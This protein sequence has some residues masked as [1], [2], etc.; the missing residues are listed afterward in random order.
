MNDKMHVL[1]LAPGCDCSDVGESWSCCQWVRGLAEHCEVTLLTLQRPGR[2]PVAGQLP[3]VHVVAWND[4]HW[5]GRLERFSSMLKPGY[6]RFYLQARRWIRNALK[7]GR[8]F[9][10]MHQLGPLAL[11]YPSP[12][13]G[14]GVPLIIGPLAG[15]LE[16]P[17][18]FEAE[19]RSAPWYTR[20]RSLD[21]LRLKFDPWLRNTY[22]SADVVI[23][24]AP[25]VKELLH[26]IPVARFEVAAETGVHDVSPTIRLPEKH[27]PELRLLY[28]GRAIRTKGL[29]DLVQAMSL[30]ADIPHLTLDAV[31]MGEDLTACRE[32]AAELHL[33]HR[34]HFHGWIPRSEVEGL[35]EQSDVF[36]FPSFREPS[37]NAVFE[38]LSHG[39]PVITTDRGGPGYVVDDE[40]GIRVPADNPAQLAQDLATAI[41]R[42]ATNSELREH[43][44]KGAAKRV[45][46]LALWPNKIS[47]MVDLYRDVTHRPQGV[48]S[49][50]MHVDECLVSSG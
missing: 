18:A 38:A 2:T 14:L 40:C 44:S 29:R 17:K 4:I 21:Q 20:L 46:Q 12:A 43:L 35:Y 5:R 1:I 19:C 47:R 13:V 22:A 23:G 32:L 26:G 6:F 41:R 49:S 28:V 3:G 50:A 16:T 48:A 33:E 15:S 30:V 27:G 10:V 7:Q 39:L 9:D 25:Y 24:V 8:R 11:R 45:R 37:G 34:I 36:V 31:G 42:I